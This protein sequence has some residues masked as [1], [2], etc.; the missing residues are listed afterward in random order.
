M[1]FSL[2]KAIDHNIDTDKFVDMYEYLMHYTMTHGMIRGK[3]ETI[4]II[5]DCKDVYLYEFPVGDLVAMGRRVKAAFKV[6]LHNVVITD[7]HW[8]LKAGT[9]IINTF[10]DPRTM[11]KMNFISDNGASYLKTIIPEDHLEQKFGGSLPNLEGNYF[12]PRYNP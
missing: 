7:I 10:V 12:P 8:L 2:R 4:T 1:V 11:G 6:V 3:I 9:K 5:V